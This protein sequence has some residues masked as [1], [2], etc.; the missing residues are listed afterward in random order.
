MDSPSLKGF[1]SQLDCKLT[2]GNKNQ[3]Q[4]TLLQYIEFYVQKQSGTK[5]EWWKYNQTG[6]TVNIHGNQQEFKNCFQISTKSA[7]SL[8]WIQA[9]IVSEKK[10]WEK[11]KNFLSDQIL[12]FV[13]IPRAYLFYQW[14]IYLQ[15]PTKRCIYKITTI[16]K[17]LFTLTLLKYSLKRVWC[18]IK[19]KPSVFSC[20]LGWLMT[21]GCYT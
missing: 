11:N 5:Q 15:L 18:H 9:Y 21:E 7:S 3:T 6:L 10:K 14:I 2:Y 20:Y 16:P 8:P 4:L 12:L 17:L 19:M 1:H 13:I